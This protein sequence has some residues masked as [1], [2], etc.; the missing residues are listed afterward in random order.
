M[1][2]TALFNLYEQFASDYLTIEF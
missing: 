2:K 1:F